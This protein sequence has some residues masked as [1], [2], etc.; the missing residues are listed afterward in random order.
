MPEGEEDSKGSSFVPVPHD[1]GKA[2]LS[3]IEKTTEGD[4]EEFKRPVNGYKWILCC[5]GLYLG[6]LLVGKYL[7]TLISTHAADNPP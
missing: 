3:D 6:A 4:E 5:V 1:V 7:H 2:G